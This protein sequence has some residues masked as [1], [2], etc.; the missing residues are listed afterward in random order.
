MTVSTTTQTKR[1]VGTGANTP[2]PT[3]FAFF[4]HSDVEVWR[5]IESTGVSTLLV[6][7]TDYTVSGGGAS[8]NQAS[9]TGT[10]TPVDGVTNFLV[11]DTWEIRRNLPILQTDF[12]VN[13]G[14]SFSALSVE[15][16]F[17]RAVMQRQQI[18][19]WV[20]LDERAIDPSVGPGAKFVHTKDDSAWPDV[21]DSVRLEI[22]GLR[23]FGGSE[24]ITFSVR[25][26]VSES[27]NGLSSVTSSIKAPASS[28]F[29]SDTSDWGTFSS[30]LVLASGGGIHGSITFNARDNKLFGYGQYLYEGYT[31]PTSGLTGSTAN[32]LGA[33]P[34]TTLTGFHF[35]NPF[36]MIGLIKF[37]GMPKR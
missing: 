1:Y 15:G 5:R 19:K 33:G 11:T 18:K 22:F 14:D 31:N 34:Y 13:Q 23:P 24:R 28:E 21:Y 32:F 3:V 36:A 10:V 35:E 4:E 2:L 8:G 9:S 27:T 17:D 7:D 20:L 6:R 29:I 12:D 26:G 30:S 37:W 16:A 25:D